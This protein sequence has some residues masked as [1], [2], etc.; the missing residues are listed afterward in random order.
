MIHGKIGAALA[1]AMLLVACASSRVHDQGLSDFD[2]GR[3]EVGLQKLAEAQASDPGNI[4][5]KADLQ[6]RREEAVQKLIAEGDK[7][8]AAGNIGVADTA[9]R[10][11]LSIESGNDRAAKGL[12]G[13]AADQRHALALKDAQQSVKNGDYD[14]AQALI[15][16]MLAEDPGYAPAAALRAQIDAARGPVTVTPKLRT[17]DDRPVTLQFRD[18][19]TKMIFE[20][21]SRQT[22][23][24]FIFD[25]DIKSD[26]KTCLLYTSPSPRD[27]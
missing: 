16:A 25:K 11:V 21:L 5:F 15:R 1:G 4:A 20:V 19:P 24:N 3:Y 17:R 10:R 26:G 8:R 14:G 9:Y 7:A 27:S 6:G 23:I 13:L 22:G 2:Q 18:A 12:A